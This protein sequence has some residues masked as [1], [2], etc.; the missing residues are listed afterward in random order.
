MPKYRKF[1]SSYIRRERHQSVNHPGGTIFE[2]DWVTI[3]GLTTLSPGKSIYYGNQNFIFTVNNVFTGQ[4]RRGNTAWVGTYNYDNVQNSTDEVNNVKPN[5][6]SNDLRSFAYYG[7][8]VELVRASIEDIISWF[9]ANMK[10][11][12]F[13]LQKPPDTDDGAY[14]DLAGFLIS[15]PFQIDLHTKNV[16]LGQW[17]NPMRYMSASFNDYTINGK[18]ITKYV[19]SDWMG[20]RDCPQNSFYTTVV[21]ITINDT[22]IRGILTD[23]TTVQYVTDDE[24]LV[25]QPKDEVIENYFNNLEGFE[26]Q[27]LNRKSTPLYSNDWKTPYRTQDENIVFTERTYTW[28]SDGYCLSIE[29]PSYEGFINDMS[30]MATMYDETYCDNLYQRMTHEAIKN[31]DW[32]YTREWVEGEEGDNV[33]GGNRMM[34]ILH[35]I[36]RFFDDIKAY[37]EGIGNMNKV[38]LDGY[39]NMPDAMLSEQANDSGWDAY[40]TIP[41]FQ[42]PAGTDPSLIRIDDGFINGFI[43]KKAGTALPQWYPAVPTDGYTTSSVDINFSRLLTLLS[44][45]IFQTKGTRQSIDMVFGMFGIGDDDYTIIEDYYTTEPKKYDAVI[46]EYTELNEHKVDL[47]YPEQ[48]EFHPLTGLPMK[49]VLIGN[50]TYIVPFYDQNK[51][52]DGNLYFQQKGGWG[53]YDTSVPGYGFLESVNYM[54]IANNITDLLSTNET[55]LRQNDYY[56]VNDISDYSQYT[57]NIPENATNYFKLSNY[58]A[59][60]ILSSWENVSMKETDARFNQADYNNVKYLDSIVSSNIGNNPHVGYGSYDLGEE[61]LDYMRKPFKYALDN[62]YMETGY[63]TRADAVQFPLVKQTDDDKVKVELTDDPTKY[64]INSKVITIRNNVNN[65]FYKQYMMQVVINYVMQVIPSTAILVLD[66]FVNSGYLFSVDPM[67]LDITSDGGTYTVK[68]Y[69]TNNGKEVGYTIDKVPDWA[70]VTK[71]ADGTL[72]VT[73]NQNTGFDTKEGTIELTQNE[74][75]KKVSVN[76]SQT[77]KANEYVFTVNPETV[78]LSPEA[79]DTDLTIVSTKNGGAI[80]YTVG[81]LP[82]WI[83]TT[84]SANGITLHAIKN[85]TATSRSEQIS[86][87][88]AETGKQVIITVTQACYQY[89][90]TA[91][92]AD[93]QVGYDA[94][95]IPLASFNVVS[96]R[97]Q[98][99]NGSMIAGT[100]EAI[101]YKST[102]AGAGATINGNNIEIEKNDGN[103]KTFILSF[104]QDDTNKTINVNIQQGTQTKVYSDVI[105]DTATVVDIPAGGGTVSACDVL[106]YHQTFG[107]NTE[108]TSG[109]TIN[110][111]A[112]VTYS[113][114]VTALSLKDTVQGRTKV[115]ELTVTVK[116]NGKIASKTIEVYQEENKLTYGEI[117]GGTFIN[118]WGSTMSTD[119]PT[120]PDFSA[121][122]ENDIPA[123]GGYGWIVMKD[124]PTQS[125][126]YTSGFSK[127]AQ[128]TEGDPTFVKAD[129]LG[130]TETQRRVVGNSEIIVTGQGGKTKTFT[131]EIY[132]QANVASEGND[133]WTITVDADVYNIPALGGDSNIT[134]TATRTVTISYTSGASTT[135]DENG[136]PTLTFD[137]AAGFSLAGTRVHATEN[138]SLNARSTTITATMGTTTQTFTVTQDEGVLTY[139]DIIVEI[140]QPQPD[141]PAGGGTVQITTADVT[142][143]QTWGWNGKTAGVG[144]V[145]TGGI[146]QIGAPVTADSLENNLTPRTIVG[147]V[148]ATVSLNGKIGTASVDI[149]QEANTREMTG[150]ELYWDPTGNGTNG[151]TNDMKVS[152]AGTNGN[153]LHTIVSKEWTYTSGFV[154]TED[155]PDYT[156]GLTIDQTWSRDA[157]KGDVSV[158]SRGSTEGPERTANVS[159]TI[160]TFTSNV[161]KLIQA[162]NVGTYDDVTGGTAQVVWSDNNTNPNIYTVGDVPA[163][164]GYGWLKETNVPVQNMSFSSGVTLNQQVTIQRTYVQG[165]D[166]EGTVTVRRKIGTATI[167]FVG[168]GGKTQVI[169]E[170]IYQEANNV[171]YGEITGMNPIAAW[172]KDR[173]NLTTGLTAGD[174][175]PTGGYGIAYDP[176]KPVQ[177]VSYTS[178]FTRNGTI[179]AN[180]TVIT[181]QNLGTTVT[182]RKLL[183]TSTVTY[184]GEGGKKATGTAQIYQAANP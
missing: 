107:Y 16:S 148:T 166:C 161:L 85:D 22:V 53:N 54:H 33:D 75:G 112:T 13:K 102:I 51:T 70:T 159:V 134:A 151:N 2:R 66:N 42:Y 39:N 144:E 60:G 182:A 117:T 27:L 61:F 9:P 140:K 4:T 87:L 56:Y 110:T 48:L 138:Q 17:D 82:D 137:N 97:A 69:S 14:Q 120:K 114:A 37:M 172:T 168:Q 149:Y 130:T 64:Y 89:T 40:T 96:N 174:I 52:Y 45:R 106:E 19:V 177:I 131:G 178:G 133:S 31:F 108:V 183:G 67:K 176:T 20:D 11:T 100:Q 63:D 142:Y 103:D 57:D 86:F 65:D 170:D 81:T 93:K 145:T 32:T 21:E 164:G 104:V 7:S 154:D 55:S 30:S 136:V 126:V 156:G 83:A 68:V 105:I 58:M 25:I 179:I 143:K 162:E 28:P 76:V 122:T 59:P 8:A 12:I 72:T 35:V 24:N 160:G 163:S 153:N 165:P 129:N 15:N 47:P 50:D 18:P 111:G 125:I 146:V 115:G 77:A 158:D 29:G 121:Y 180:P 80:G 46:D 23:Y 91:N 171:T 113:T 88:Q 92:T 173:N 10:A 78:T 119:N 124:D 90:F 3:G 5:Q 109:G 135:K 141:V 95:T 150:V 116:L 36:G 147:Q 167:S 99:I 84:N 43:T 169:S 181:G 49:E 34:E 155:D 74:S 26:K 94:T 139:S 38:T 79:N 1:S 175:P 123:K 101:G 73:V 98:Y 152:A 6:S 184:T 157:G 128:V 41:S 44:K 62:Y 127:D 132:Q 118:V 71:N